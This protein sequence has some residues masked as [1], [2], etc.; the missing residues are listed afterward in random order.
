MVDMHVDFLL[1]NF[2]LFNIIR[3]GELPPYHVIGGRTKLAIMTTTK[4]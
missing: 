2:G 4:I 1:H 3:F